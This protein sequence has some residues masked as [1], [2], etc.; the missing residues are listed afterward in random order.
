MKF[1]GYLVVSR[2]GEVRHLKNRP[3][4]AVGQAILPLNL[5]IPEAFFDPPKLPAVEIILDEEAI[6]RLKVVQE[7]MDLLQGANIKVRLVDADR[8]ERS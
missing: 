8:E 2:N 7:A 4:E 5:E 6:P 1:T 3:M